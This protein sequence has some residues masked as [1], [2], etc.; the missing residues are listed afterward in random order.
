MAGI[1]AGCAARARPDPVPTE[2]PRA[3]GG[4]YLIQVGDTLDVRFYATPELNT[5]V[6]VRGDGSISLELVG[7]V[8]AAGLS[9]E[10]LA[11]VLDQRYAR[12]LRDPA[13]TVMVQS[14]GGKVFVAGEVQRPCAVGFAHG[15][16]ALQAIASAGGFRDSANLGNVILLRQADGQVHGHRLSLDRAA[17]GDDP[18][19]DVP[20]QPA[21]VLYVPRTRI[22]KVDL[23]VEQYVRKVLPDMPYIPPFFF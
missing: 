5:K 19:A 23:F 20:L 12:E 4:P 21:D 11:K 14:F 9:P 8:R 17:S 15:M 22:A 10:A 16:T 13:V 18:P 2:P 7:E 3:T 1:V 6:P